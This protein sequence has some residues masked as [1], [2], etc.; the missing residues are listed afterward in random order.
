[1]LMEV[2]EIA[3]L[4]DDPRVD[5][6]VVREVLSKVVAQTNTASIEVSRVEGSQGY[7][8]FVKIVVRGVNGR[9]R[10]GGAP[11][12][13][14][15]GRLGGIGAR[16]AQIGL[17]SDADGAIACLSAALKLLKMQARG[18]FLQGDVILATHV[19]PRAPVIPHEPVPLM[20]SPVDMGTMNRYEVDSAMEAILSIDTTRG[21][22]ILNHKG[23]AIT[24]TV[25][26]GWI[27]R[28]WP[29]LL[30]VYEWVTG[31]PPVILPLS[32]GDITPY[33]NGVYHINSIVQPATVTKAPVVG[34]AITAKTV[35]PG[36][37]TG[38][39]HEV[40]IALA[41]RFVL[42][43]AKKFTEGQLRFY[44]ETEFAR[45]VTRYGPMNILQT[46][47]KDGENVS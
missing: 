41:A 20:G 27:L 10:G 26:E 35:V 16:P 15:I 31:E 6:Y 33:G 36:S 42:E 24:P 37:A 12:I 46:L 47:G 19:C 45:L 28:P 39:N 8:D 22:R 11:T 34:V 23:I 30:D 9:S 43:V 13:G 5:G 25:K 7:T 40:D 44:D 29:E 21:N 38:A 18:D 32:M 17:V 3:D 1:M 14:I 2:L 4:L